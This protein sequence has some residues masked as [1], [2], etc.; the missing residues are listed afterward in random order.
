MLAFALL[1]G[2]VAYPV[3]LDPDPTIEESVSRSNLIPVSNFFKNG[4]GS[5]NGMLR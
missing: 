2:R 5:A 3:E 1:K 4:S